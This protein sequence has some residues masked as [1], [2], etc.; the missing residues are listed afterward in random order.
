VSVEIISYNKFRNSREYKKFYSSVLVNM[1][2]LGFIPL[3]MEDIEE[4]EKTINAVKQHIKI[5]KIKNGKI[6]YYRTVAGF[7]LPYL[8]IF[9]RNSQSYQKVKK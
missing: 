2:H 8:Y 7:G 5:R 6:V 1:N 9:W 4:K 3:Y